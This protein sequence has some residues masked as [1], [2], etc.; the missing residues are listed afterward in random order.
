MKKSIREINSWAYLF[1]QSVVIAKKYHL[2][3]VL[4]EYLSLL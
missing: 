1:S 2:A 4:Q 3:E